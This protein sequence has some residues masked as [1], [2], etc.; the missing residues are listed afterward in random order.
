MKKKISLGIVATLM[1]AGAFVFA[2]NGTTKKADNICPD[3]P[4][5]ICSKPTTT[6]QVV[7]KPTAISEK[8][9]NCPNTPNCICK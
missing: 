1:V 4:G 7:A 5:C 3:R 2:N 6:A 9:G 8:K